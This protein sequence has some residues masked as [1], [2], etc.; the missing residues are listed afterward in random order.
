MDTPHPT[1]GQSQSPSRVRVRVG[2][3]SELIHTK[4]TTPGPFHNSITTIIN[5]TKIRV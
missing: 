5:F 3:E 4:S 1:H 2:A